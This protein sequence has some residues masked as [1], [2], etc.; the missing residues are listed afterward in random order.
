MENSLFAFQYMEEDMTEIT[1]PDTEEFDLLDYIDNVPVARDE[2]SVYTDLGKSRRLNDLM[3]SREEELANRREAERQGKVPNL[4]L[5]DEDED[6]EFDTEINELIADLEKTK[7]TI[8]LKSVAPELRKSIT[9]HYKATAPKDMTP[10]EAQRYSER[11]TADILSRAI[12]SVTTGRGAVDT[13]PFTP[14]RLIELEVKLYETQSARLISALWT[15]VHD[16]SAFER[17][18]TLDF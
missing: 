14:D 8:G 15:M 12:E 7:V 10:E 3:T 5:A 6:T 1:L 18:I 9:K 4:S 17:A 13:T 16:A 11:E 2:I